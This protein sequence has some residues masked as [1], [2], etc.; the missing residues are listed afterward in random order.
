MAIFIE[1]P[2][3]A[4][5]FYDLNAPMIVV[6]GDSD[7]KCDSSRHR[8]TA[9]YSNQEYADEFKLL[10]LLCNRRSPS[11]RSDRLRALSSESRNSM[12]T[13]NERECT[14]ML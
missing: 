6:R 4:A 12:L 11:D 14:L 2:G 5:A 7:E 9:K 13:T 10:H 8:Y 3:P 1:V